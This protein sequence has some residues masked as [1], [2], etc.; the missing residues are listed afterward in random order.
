MR[1]GYRY[2]VHIQ[3]KLH[4]QPLRTLEYTKEGVFIRGTQSYFI[5]DTFRVR[6]D[7]V[8]EITRRSE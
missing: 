3:I 4:T 7:N 2:I 5:F 6:K 8:L 1:R